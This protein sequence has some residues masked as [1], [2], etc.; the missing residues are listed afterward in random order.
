MNPWAWHP[1]PDVWLLIGVLLLGYFVAVT[2]LGPRFVT[3]G[4]PV[5][6]SRQRNTFLAGVAVLWLG[7]AWP[8]HDLSEDYLL[9]VHMLQHLAFTLVAPGLMM[10]GLPGWMWR[11]ALSPP[12]VAAVAK[13]M[14]RPLP[15]ALLFNTVIVL[16]HWPAVV[17][18]ALRSEP[19]HFAVHAV[20]VS[21]AVIMWFPVVN[22]Q[23]GFPMLSYPGRMVYLFLQSVIPTVPAS[24]LTF[25]NGVIYEFYGE[26][27][28]AFGVSAVSDQQ[29]AGGIMKIVG[30][31]TLWSVIVVM[32]FRWY[33]ESNGEPGKT[34]TWDDVE[35]EL[36][37]TRSAR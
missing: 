16:S 30:G 36:E 4:E 17:D 24:F 31:L 9:S 37:R 32:F 23:L 14:A 35:R 13:K 29:M 33:R 8:V 12:I 21:S 3:P 19:L 25:A 18:A 11:R 10:V 34:L 27:P 26:A 7:A 15:A 5:V 2:Q 6:T 22:R 1:H 28:R 20:L